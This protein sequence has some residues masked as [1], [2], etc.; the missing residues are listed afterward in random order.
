MMSRLNY[1]LLLTFFLSA[2]SLGYAE[3]PEQNKK[4]EEFEGILKTYE[5]QVSKNPNNVK[6]LTALGDVYYSLKDYPKAIIYYTRALNIEPENLS[7]KISLAQSYLNDNDLDT[8]QKLFKEIIAKDPKNATVLGALGR[9]QALKKHN[10]EAEAYYQQALE[11]DP[12]HFTTLFYLGDLRNKQKRYIEAEAIF[13]KLLSRDPKATWVQSS[14]QAAIVG[15]VLEEAKLLEQS[16]NY[17]Q[18]IK[19]YQNQL[20]ITPE[21]IELYLSLGRLYLQLKQYQDAIHVL[22]QGLQIYPEEAALQLALANTYLAQ[23]ELDPARKIFN[24]LLEKNKGR[25]EA[26]GGLGK[27]AFLKGKPKRAER[28]YKRSLLLDPENILT[29]SY[30]A[31]LR[32]KEKKYDEALKIYKNILKIDPEAIW[33]RDLHEQARTAPLFDLIHFEEENFNEEKAEK[34]YEQLIMVSPLAENYLKFGNFYTYYKKDAQAQ[35][36]FRQGL[37]LF[38]KNIP[39]GL[40]LANSYL[41]SGNYVESLE[42]YNKILK[43][44]P[45]NTDALSGIGRVYYTIGDLETSSEIYQ[46]ILEDHPQDLTTLSYFADLLSA[47]KDY[48]SAK[49]VYSTILKIDPKA[50]WA[51]E[52]IFR[53]EFGNIFDEI[54]TLEKEG[55]YAKATNLYLNLLKEQPENEILYLE[56]G[57]LYREQKREDR[58]IDIY[59]KGL[60]IFPSSL[61]LQNALAFTYLQINQTQKAE[62]LFY[63]ILQKDP[64]HSEAFAGLGQIAFRKKDYQKAFEYYRKA[65]STNPNNQ[66]N[67]A[68]FGEFWTAQKDFEKAIEAYER[69]L[70]VNPKA[71]WAKQAIE[72]AKLAPEILKINQQGDYQRFEK[73]IALYTKLIRENPHQASY[74]SKLAKIFIEKKE[75][76]NAIQVYLTGLENLPDNLDLQTSL[77]FALIKNDELNRAHAI[78]IN[79]LKQDENQAEALAGLGKIEALIGNPFEANLFYEQALQIDPYNITALISLAELQYSTGHY[80]QAF[81]LYKKVHKLIPEALWVSQ[82]MEDAKH[83]KLLQAIQEKENLKE[84]VQADLLWQQLLQESPKSTD[85]YLR[86]GLFYE[87]VKQYDKAIDTFQRGL[88]AAPN[89]SALYSA[90]GL[91][92]LSKK[93]KQDAYKAFLKSYRL[94]AQ[95]PD[96]IAGLG[97][98]AFLNGQYN[99]A[100]KWIRDALA[101]DPDRIFALSSLG[102]L[103]MKLKHY[104]DAQSVYEKLL[105]L[106]PHEKWIE[107]SLD[108]AKYGYVLDHIEKLILN[109]Q[110]A[111]AA[112]GYEELLLLAPTNPH[113]Y[114]GLGQMQMRLRQYAKSI[115]TN[116]EGLQKNPDDNEL[117]IALGFAYFLNN[118]LV[119]ARQVLL[120]ALKIDPK[121]PEALAGLGRVNALEKNDCE[122]ERLYWQAIELDPKN[123]SALSFLS[124]LLMKQKRY[125]EAQEI[126]LTVWQLLPNE[127]WVQR[128]WQDAEDGAVTDLANRFAA[129]EHFEIALNLYQDLL[130]RSPRDPSRYLPL[131]QMYVNLKHYYSGIDI[132]QQGLQ[133]DREAWYLWRAIAF[134]YIM[135]EEFETAENLFFFVLENVPE[136]AE[137]L[138]GLGRIEALNGSRCAAKELYYRALAAD[139]KNLTALSFLAELYQDEQYNFSSLQVY[140]NI[141]DLLLDNPLNPFPKWA[142]RGYSNALNLTF[143]TISL[144]GAYHEEDQWDPNVKKWSAEYLVYGGKALINYPICDKFT[145]WGSVADQLYHLRDLLTHTY[146]YSFDV[147]RFHLGAKWVYSPCFYI[148]GKIGLVNYSPYRYS[149][150]IMQHGVFGEPSLS[151]VYHQPKERAT[152]SFLTDSDLIA[153]DF[154]TNR[155]KVVRYSLLTGTYERKIIKRGWIGGEATNYWFNDYVDNNSQKV[156]GW[157]QWRPPYYSDYV[158]FR[159][160]CKFQTFAKNIPDYYT[161]KPQIINHLQVTLENNWRVCWADTLYTS[162]S[163]GYGWQNTYTRFT[164]II[165][166]DPLQ[167]ILPPYVW[168]NRRYNIVVGTLIYKYDR[169][170]FTFVGDYYRDS[171]KYT[172][173]NLGADFK[174]RF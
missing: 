82:A 12:N 160:H 27:I 70:E 150:F 166:V 57:E 59:L 44:V 92:Y 76:N 24:Q 10:Y 106:R 119:E 7:I 135:L 120:D 62:T 29:L 48:S 157:F 30:M 133:I 79:V 42:T 25:S 141:N 155:A 163:Y 52:G 73:L 167:N 16:Q 105:T 83:G 60:K 151:L 123:L 71:F 11:K 20:K 55:Q 51:K 54:Q 162:L 170:Q 47:T 122:A 18:A 97:Y 93:Q 164:Q 61:L 138:A 74:Y 104:H 128:G 4:K 126:Y 115:E 31:E 171:E 136:D 32:M 13:K 118:N 112:S 72:E 84:Y 65:Y 148:E 114:Y 113:Y 85:Y 131:G 22:E 132:F 127:E 158:L 37:D 144:A 99:K 143:A 43:F 15:P 34:L 108:D 156:L 56:I 109:H 3:A 46:W 147:Q 146:I 23:G 1:S 67:L 6:L 121:Q 50:L 102:E 101:I 98:V 81:K 89:S 100:E 75:V 91:A 145:I 153:R 53:S 90:M 68:Y 139:S 130:E 94:D 140:E 103:W 161:Y 49:K 33:I 2:A 17:P 36:I 40:A 117:R 95:N 125:A 159:Y 64:R 154:S 8:S 77:G 137:S 110:Y 39:L 172:I 86:A 88:K 69:L 66:R 169:L 174:W 80:R 152:L 21:A 87:K 5:E 111:E 26:F 173:W 45:E 142:R 38:P 35:A 41:Q 58:A 134:T 107:I 9:I 14:Y 165:V 96:A 78:F 124:D 63:E 28:F 149:T 129:R 168:D 116:L 19:I